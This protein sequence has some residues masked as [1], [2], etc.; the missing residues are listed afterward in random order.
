MIYCAK[1]GCVFSPNHL[2]PCGLTVPDYWAPRLVWVRAGRAVF[3]ALRSGP[4]PGEVH[5]AFK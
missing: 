1:G 3:T 4:V 5:E 2:G